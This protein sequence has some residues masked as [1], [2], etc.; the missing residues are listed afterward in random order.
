M[1]MGKGREMGLVAG[2][3]NL[4]AFIACPTV[5]LEVTRAPRLACT[6]G[7]ILCVRASQGL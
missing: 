1:K 2:G 3:S 4:I 5:K 6:V 7:V